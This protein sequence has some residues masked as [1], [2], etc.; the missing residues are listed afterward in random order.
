MGRYSLFLAGLT[1]L[2]LLLCGGCR[3]QT[4]DACECV[5]RCAEKTAISRP[6]ALQRCT[7]G[8]KA[9]SPDGYEEGHERATRFLFEQSGSCDEES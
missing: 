1:A 6:D 5:V 4:V 7:A 8:C 9:A 3:D 2:A